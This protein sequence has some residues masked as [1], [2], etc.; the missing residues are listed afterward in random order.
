M[1]AECS[2]GYLEGLVNIPAS[3]SMMQ[4]A[5]A[6]ALLNSGRTT[7]LNPGTSNDDKAAL[8][9]IQQLGAEVIYEAGR[10][11]ITSKG[12][13]PQTDVLHCGESG[14]SA[15]LFI[16]IAATCVQAL[17]ITGSGSLLTRPFDVY[18]DVLPKLGVETHSNGGR[19]PLTI[20]G[21]LIPADT[22]IDG[23]LSSQFLS[24]LL[25]S[26]AFSA[27]QACTITVKDLH[28]KPYVDI[29]LSV[30]E[31][32]GRPITNS[33]YD[34][35]IVDPSNFIETNNNEIT[36]EGDWSSAAAL[37]VGGA[38]AGD[39]TVDG[40]WEHSLQA[41]N[42]IMDVLFE[43]KTLLSFGEGWAG[44]CKPGA[45]KPFTFDATNAPDLFPVLSVL[46][47]CCE[48]ESEIKGIHRL[49][50]KESNRIV[51]ISEMLD[52]LGVQ[53]SV[54]DDSL[55]IEGVETL[56]SCTIDSYNDHRIVMAAAIA[57]LRCDGKVV[58][59]GAEAVSKSYPDFFTHLQALGAHCELKD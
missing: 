42:A 6:A 19:L 49:I 41:D 44:T 11:I 57:A 46:A 34:T 28:S 18:A 16:P 29:T 58:I 9:L 53:H 45:L 22:T 1:R 5:C 37:L 2:F 59:E 27:K 56:S 47:A 17:Q 3:K 35:F 40:I 52:R 39:I 25:F 4:R 23:S 26:Y 33:G 8:S 30:L 43:T 13:D 55:F 31:Q 7:I 38:I 15:R 21:P 48:G 12:I 20:H 36:I 10:I 51:S 32:F 24:G 50:H 14:L 54:A